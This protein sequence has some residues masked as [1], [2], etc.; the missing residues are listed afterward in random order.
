MLGLIIKEYFECFCIKKNLLSN[1]F[2]ILC[3]ILMLAIGR[4]EYIYILCFSLIFPMMSVAV[5]EAA[6]TQDEISKFDEILLTYPITK[7]E[8]ILS[9]YLSTL[10][11]IVFEYAFAFIFVLLYS[12]ALMYIHF[13]LHLLSGDLA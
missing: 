10:L 12:F 4:Y 11:F 9:K 8:I 6:V 2:G 3:T 5:C 7:N 1:G 13:K